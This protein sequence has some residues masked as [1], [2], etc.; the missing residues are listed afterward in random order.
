MYDIEKWNDFIDGLSNDN[1]NED[2]L[3]DATRK[4]I[5]RV[6]RV[7]EPIFEEIDSMDHNTAAYEQA[8]RHYNDSKSS[9]IKV[10]KV[11]PYEAY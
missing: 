10:A 6:I 4:K 1:L 8:V 3:N 11:L 5:F 7:L 9:L 2:A